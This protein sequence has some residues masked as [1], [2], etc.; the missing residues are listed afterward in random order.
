M[1]G[2]S[3]SGL[4][5]GVDTSAV[6][7]QLTAVD[8][9][10]QARLKLRQSALEARQTTLTDVKTRLTNL[11]SQAKE[12]GSSSAWA[13][14]QSVDVSD[15]SKLAAKRL[16]GAAPGGHEIAVSNLA[17]SEQRSYAFTAGT[18]SSLTLTTSSGTTTVPLSATDDGAAAADKINSAA[19]SPVYAVWVEDPTGD[20][21]KDRL[22]LTR[23][24]TG[25]Y[26]QGELTVG[27]AS[28]ASSETYAAGVDARYSVDGGTVQTSRSNVVKA[29]V[30]GLELT[31]KATG[32]SAVTVGNPGPDP[33]AVKE[34]VK[35]FVSQYNS[36]IEFIR[37]KL[38]EKPVS[39][40]TTTSEAA[41]GV[42][43]G[44]SQL[45]GVLTQLRNLVS[46]KVSGLSGS[47]TSLR[48]IG[49]STG[50]ATSGTSSAD[51]LAG[52]LT[53]DEDALT[54]AL[55][56]DRIDVRAFLT[57]STKGIATKLTSM[58]DPLTKSGGLV[59]QRATQAGNQASS[60]DDQIKKMS[61][62]LELK[63]ERL[64]AQFAAM[65]LALQRSQTTSGWLSSQLSSL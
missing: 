19:G 28:W 22:V 64:K 33:A 23:K 21:T 8:A 57:D 7:E 20:T 25:A 37:G 2:L 61:E 31:L 50:K 59:D 3:L 9:A 34:K 24:E 52:K 30:P 40:A 1:A 26:L 5:S 12:L 51:S 29:A 16:S 11:L 4:A 65:E 43:F 18:A 62:R 42:L 6:I 47:V 14:T 60:I 58:L 44:D 13:D 15:G 41:K 54:E 55:E 17:R 36:T 45:T 53:I 38:N 10:G 48:D 35:A 46:D 56:N 49:V 32:T 27:G 39:G 63:A